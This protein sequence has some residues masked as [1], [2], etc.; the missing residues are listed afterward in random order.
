LSKVPADNLLGEPSHGCP[1][2]AYSL[3]QREQRTTWSL[4]NTTNV[5]QGVV[6]NGISSSFSKDDWEQWLEKNVV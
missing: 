2:H 3:V 4:E 1:C 6:E 5:M